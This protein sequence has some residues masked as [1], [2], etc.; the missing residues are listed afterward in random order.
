MRISSCK[1]PKL[2]LGRQSMLECLTQ[3]RKARFGVTV[4]KRQYLCDLFDPKAAAGTVF[5]AKILELE[6]A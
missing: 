1:F 3:G 5:V 4:F 2:Q 6:C